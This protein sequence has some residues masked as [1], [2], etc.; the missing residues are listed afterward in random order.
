MRAPSP[1]TL[2]L[3]GLL[4]LPL[5]PLP[6]RPAQA[7]EEA[8]K[9][10]WVYDVRVVQVQAD[11][12]K[13][14]A[15]APWETA[16]STVTS[17]WAEHLTALQAR[18]K[19]F[20]MLDQRASGLWRQSSHLETRT[21]I[22]IRRFDNETT[23]GVQVRRFDRI[24]TGVKVQLKASEALSYQVSV[25]WVHYPP[26]EGAVPT[27]TT[28]WQGTHPPITDGRTLALVH[29]EHILGRSGEPELAEIHCF[30]TSRFTAK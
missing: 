19:I 7:E 26:Q 20:L 4:A 2:L 9:G 27:A 1:L 24:D 13:G 23:G 18:G 12:V 5:V 25:N 11:P 30:I 14:L 28:S 29:R 8:R 10:F 17:S 3:L 6:H 15:P 22:P 16:G 21:T